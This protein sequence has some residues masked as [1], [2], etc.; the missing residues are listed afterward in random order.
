MTYDVNI[1]ESKPGTNDDCNTGD[2]FA[3]REEAERAYANPR[4]AFPFAFQGVH[5]ERWV[6]IDGPD[7]HEERKVC[8]PHPAHKPDDMSDWRNEFAM[9]QGMGLGVNAYNDAK[10]Y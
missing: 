1:W 3:T 4:E 2:E 6:E 7:I 8:G 10:G 5:G 9:Q